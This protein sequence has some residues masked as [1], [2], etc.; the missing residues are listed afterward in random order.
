MHS[1]Q[2]SIGSRKSGCRGIVRQSLVSW[3]FVAAR[4]ARG[5]G[6]GGIQQSKRN[7]VAVV[8]VKG[9]FIEFINREDGLK[10]R[11]WEL[12]V[13]IEREGRRED[14]IAHCNVVIAI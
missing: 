6:G 9:R 4:V 1:S 14:C 10:I 8:R 13:G 11:Q 12:E 7:L 5:V 2:V 3:R